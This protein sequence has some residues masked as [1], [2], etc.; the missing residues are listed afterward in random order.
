MQATPVIAVFDI[1]KTNKK[2]LLFDEEYRIVLETARCIAETKDD[3]GD[4]CDDLEQISD[5]VATSLE[6]LAQ[7]KKYQLRAVNFATYGASFVHLDARGQPVAPLYNYLKAF[8]EQLSDSFYA[9]YGGREAFSVATASPV[10]GHLNSGMQ[11]YWLKHAKPYLY[12]SIR[13]SLH[14]PQ[15]MCFLLSGS[16][17]SD[18]TSIGCHTGLWDFRV[19]TYHPWVQQ[20][21]IAEKLAPVVPS[22][23]VVA[24]TRYAA[25]NVG[26]GLHDSS[27]ALIPYLA[28]FTEPFVLISTGT[29]CISLNPFNKTPLTYAELQQDCLCYL[30]YEGRP[31]KASRLF[32]GHEHE[33][34]VQWLAAYFQ[35]RPDYFKTV[36]FDKN[37]LQLELTLPVVQNE[38]AG[39]HPSGKASHFPLSDLSFFATYEAAYHQLVRQLVARQAV[40][41]NLV[42]NGAP[43]KKIFVDGGFSH[44][45]VYMHLLAAA[46]PQIEVYAA[47][48]AQASALGA[49]LAIHASW[50]NKPISKNIIALKHFPADNDLA[51]MMKIAP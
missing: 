36:R 37:E 39:A 21:G 17:C 40:A 23:G 26:T 49:A 8:P 11:L 10:L 20:E 4:P 42:L 2:L 48:M 16:H 15:Y 13:Y 30:S 45:Q 19:G 6:Q 28:S 46:F 47:T 22:T 38:L 1:G 27:A 44:N 9:A 12:A 41:T 3:D 50:N 31:V 5:F 35:K 33:Q 29:W 32:A 24:A 7:S 34:Q 25:C 43:V 14:L 51:N 18:Q